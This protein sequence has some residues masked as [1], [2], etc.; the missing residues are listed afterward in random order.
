IARNQTAAIKV[1]HF[2]RVNSSYETTVT[3]SNLAG[4]GL[5]SGV[6]FRRAFLT[7]E[8]LDAEG[9][10]LWASGR[11]NSAG[12]IVDGT[13]DE[14]LATEFFRDAKSGK[15]TFQPHYQVIDSE[16]QVQI[17]EELVADSDGVITTSFVG[18][19]H[20]LKNNR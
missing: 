17:Y 19:D 3:V 9:K 6:E 18:L 5:P 13:N 4:H 11:T 16:N 12:A 10:V 20:V 1:G 7:F 8:L 15:Q 14:V 2:K